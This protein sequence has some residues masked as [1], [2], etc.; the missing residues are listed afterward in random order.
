M[1]PVGAGL[2]EGAALAL[3]A[4]LALLVAPAESSGSSALSAACTL[5][6]GGGLISGVGEPEHA[7][8]AL[9]AARRKTC[10]VERAD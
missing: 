9:S 4:A 2:L 7:T 8:A 10:V 3:C 1:G 5:A 6:L